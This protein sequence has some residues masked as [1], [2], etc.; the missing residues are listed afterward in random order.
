M[1]TAVTQE[2]IKELVKHKDLKDIVEIA[3]LWFQEYKEYGWKHT[4]FQVLDNDTKFEL[5]SAIRFPYAI[6]L[7]EDEILFGTLMVVLRKGL[8]FFRDQNSGLVFTNGD[9]KL[10][11]NK[12][13]VKDIEKLL[14]KEKEND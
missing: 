9:S 1:T 3:N 11:H 5:N 7:S 12:Q 2:R 10:D 6:V 8:W 13:W 14:F 4:R